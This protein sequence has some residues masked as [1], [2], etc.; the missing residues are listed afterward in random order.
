MT[1]RATGLSIGQ[2][3]ERTGLSVHALRYYE[4]EGVLADTVRR[5]R[6]GRRV[7]GEDDVEWLAMC[8]R[9]RET[10]MPLPAIRRYADLVRQ[11]PGNEKERLAVLREHQERVSDRIRALGECLDVI[12][13]KV[14]VYEDHLDN[15][16]ADRLWSGS[17]P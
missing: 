11:G 3:A 8:A 5:D 14:R 17:E 15:G 10:G 9:F 2:V 6:G 4:R 12:A 13:Y 16:T 1:D 7:Y